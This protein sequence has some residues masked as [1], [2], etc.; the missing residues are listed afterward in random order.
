M[1]QVIP[2]LPRRRVEAEILLRVY[3][4]LC[5]RIGTDA[6]LQVIV[7]AVEASAEA[8]GREFARQAPG[9][10]S[11][12]HFATVVDR[13]R[14]G[15]ALDVEGPAIRGNVLELTVTRCAYAELY[16]SMRLPEALARILSCRRDA[17][18][19][20]GYHPSLRL[21]R[22]PTLAEGAPACRFRFVWE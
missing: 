7:A 3:T 18:F 2:L 22:S 4:A 10:P 13:W 1:G 9:G 17:A 19:A 6:A 15:G 5:P 16:R 12:E 11:L 21:E 8:A 14:E 20:R